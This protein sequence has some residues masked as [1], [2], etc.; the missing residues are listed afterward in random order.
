[1]GEALQLTDKRS[2]AAFSTFL[3]GA[4]DVL[5][6]NDALLEARGTAKEMADKQLDNL[7][8]AVTI[9]NSAW[10]GFILS[11][12]D[13]NGSFARTLK[14]IVRVVTELLSL[15]SGTEKLKSELTESELKVREFAESIITVSKFVGVL[16]VGFVAYKAAMIASRIATLA[17]AA[18]N[19]IATTSFKALNT[20]MKANVIGLVVSVLATL[21][22]SMKLFSSET[23]DATE[24]QR[25]FNEEQ[26]ALADQLKSIE[27]RYKIREK[28]SKKQLQTLRAEIQEQLDLEE[29]RAGVLKTQEDL[30]KSRNEAIK[31]QNKADLEASKLSIK[32]IDDEIAALEAKKFTTLDQ[33]KIDDDEISRLKLKKKELKDTE[34]LLQELDAF[35]GK[36][37][38]GLSLDKIEKDEAR[39]AEINKLL[40][41][42]RSADSSGGKKSAVAGLLNENAEALKKAKEALNAATSEEGIQQELKNIK[43]L[44]K[45][46]RR[47]LGITAQEKKDATIALE[48][49]IQKIE[50]QYAIGKLDADRDTELEG[51]RIA[52]EIKR[53]EIEKSTASEKV[54]N[55]KLLELEEQTLK[56]KA[57]INRRYAKLIEE[58]NLETAYKAQ[59]IEIANS[60]ATAE[61]IE[62]AE[63]ASREKHKQDL[64]AIDR[65]YAELEQ[66]QKD[67]E[68][69][70]EYAKEQELEKKK[71]EAQRETTDLAINAGLDALARLNA[72]EQEK[73]NNEIEANKDQISKQQAL[74]TEGLEN[75]LAFEEAQLAKLEKKKLD[76]DK[77]AIRLEKI[78][79]L[80]A[81]YSA[82][83]S[84]GDNQAIVKVL[85]DFAIIQGIETAITSFGT[86]TGEYGTF[87]DA[88]EAKGGSKGGNSIRKGI[89]KGEKHNTRGFGIP[90]LVEGDEGLL[91]GNQMNNLGKDNF[92]KLA[93]ALDKGVL[94]SDIFGSQISLV[95]QI[96][97]VSVDFSSLQ[98]EMKDVKR[99]IESKPVPSLHAESISETITDLVHTVRAG[100]KTV[101]SRYRI[102]KRRL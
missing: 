83:A 9:L 38:L 37:I 48:K 97:N 67:D 14:N 57:E 64:A 34:V 101:K 88:L 84:S 51:A 4:D 26:K 82:A 92:I 99:A 56:E 29:E 21:I 98:S 100:S 59:R 17:M 66:K 93:S 42:I 90:V 41:E 13:G 5:E 95:P 94:G 96:N 79:A 89:V 15:A 81:A 74:A 73:I 24:A 87:E 71:R 63:T 76:A 12:E 52:E 45:E 47:L 49:E 10:E 68:R 86:G 44:E 6:L 30:I 18:A 62:K 60:K 80:Y 23:D 85:S 72:A 91:S 39:I 40:S 46:R 22:A 78:K 50:E 33:R 7:S 28:L 32:A 25:K 1:L 69:K 11:L 53:E 54:K 102:N 61:A 8:G 77:K 2:V 58:E 75:T 36:D 3:N 27:E 43:L 65:K 35:D 70:K 31:E 19:K 55:E 20:A 16:V